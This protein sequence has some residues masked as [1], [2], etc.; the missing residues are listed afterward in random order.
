MNTNN[1]YFKAFQDDINKM[2]SKKLVQE[3][4]LQNN[5]IYNKIQRELSPPN[6][7]YDMDKKFWGT[8][9]LATRTITLSYQLLRNHKWDAVVHTLKHEM[10]H[11]IV[12]EL[13]Y[14]I[15]D[16]G[17]S[18]GELFNKACEI[19]GVDSSSSN[20]SEELSKYS[21]PEKD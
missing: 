18:H 4:H 11:M 3:F 12:S 17:N 13:W 2:W 5:L 21:I 6:F 15:S 20:S 9:T 19:L 1:E 16:N 8:W 7:A 14:D 10:A